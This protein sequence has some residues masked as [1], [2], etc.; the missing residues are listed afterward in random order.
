MF[1]AN[2]IGIKYKNCRPWDV[3]AVDLQQ[4]Y[5]GAG[6]YKSSLKDIAEDLGLDCED[7]IEVEDEFTYYYSGDFDTLKKSAIKKAEVMCQSHRIL[8][9]LPKLDI[10]FVEEVVKD[11]VE[12]KPKDWLKELYYVNQMTEE[13][14][15]GLKQQIFGGKKKPT[16]KELEHLFTIIRGVYVMTDFESG[17][18]DSKKT[19]EFKEQEIKEL[20]YE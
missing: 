10:Q 17:K 20:L 19:I 4:F 5:D 18:N 2:H 3:K 13:I 9:D 14:K 6:N 15:E 12:E 11:V 1:T 16:K 7:I 8:L